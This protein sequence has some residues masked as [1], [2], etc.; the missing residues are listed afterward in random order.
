MARSAGR[1]VLLATLLVLALASPAL[2]SHVHVR[3]LGN[4]QSVILAAGGGETWVTLP[5]AVF[6]NNPNVVAGAYAADRRHPLHVL[7]HLA[8]AGGGMVYVLGSPGDLANCN[9]YVND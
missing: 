2:A 1:A 5:D 8:G 7:V 4:G 3:V 9:G 6:E